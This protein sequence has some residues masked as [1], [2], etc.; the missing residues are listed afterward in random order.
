MADPRG[1]DPREAERDR[2]ELVAEL[3]DCR[4]GLA[5]DDLATV[6]DAV[7]RVEVAAQRIGEA[8]YATAEPGGEGG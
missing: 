2:D 7:A 4:A 1:H 5:V 8:I 6:L 3:A